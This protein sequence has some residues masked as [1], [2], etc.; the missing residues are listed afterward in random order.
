MID[1]NKVDNEEALERNNE[2][3]PLISMTLMTNSG[4]C[5]F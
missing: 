5:E 4:G 1:D 3:F 2:I